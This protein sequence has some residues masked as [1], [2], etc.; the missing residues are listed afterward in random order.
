MLLQLP[1]QLQLVM[2]LNDTKL[3]RAPRLEPPLAQR[4]WASP[5]AR[6]RRCLPLYSRIIINSRTHSLLY[7]LGRVAE[8]GNY[9]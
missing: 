2:R 7:G 8:T 4:L 9:V 3:V 6:A 1:C 5:P